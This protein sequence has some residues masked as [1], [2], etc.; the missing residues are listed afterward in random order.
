ME[1]RNSGAGVTCKIELD[2]KMVSFVMSG[3]NWRVFYF[4][5]FE[6]SGYFDPMAISTSEAAAHIDLYFASV[7]ASEKKY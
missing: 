7:L 4:C 2:L 3:A 6:L 5:F 1:W